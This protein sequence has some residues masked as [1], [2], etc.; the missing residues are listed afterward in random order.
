MQE[1]DITTEVGIC[2]TGLADLKYLAQDINED[3]F[4]AFDGNLD[5]SSIMYL[6][7]DV[8][9]YAALF[10]ILNLRLCDIHKRIKN[11]ENC[12]TAK[13]R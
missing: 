3:F 10:R 5:E 1:I 6:A 13:G 4:E 11:I 2:E 12:L 7:N 9:R 8:S